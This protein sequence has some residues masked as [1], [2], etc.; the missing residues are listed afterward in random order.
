MKLI[1]KTINK[2][3]KPRQCQL[4]HRKLD[5]HGCCIRP[6]HWQKEGIEIAT[7]HLQYISRFISAN[8]LWSIKSW[9]FYC[10]IGWALCWS[11]RSIDTTR[12]MLITAFVKMPYRADPRSVEDI[13]FYVF[14]FLMK[15]WTSFVCPSTTLS[16]TKKANSSMWTKKRTSCRIFT[17]AGPEK[18]VS[19]T[20]RCL[21]LSIHKGGELCYGLCSVINVTQ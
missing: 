9:L 10:V 7:A 11:L 2:T 21:L 1:L 4:K 3:S 17:V 5:G 13:L 6:K 12:M 8:C 14:A 16:K 19:I 20:K 18:V 15:G